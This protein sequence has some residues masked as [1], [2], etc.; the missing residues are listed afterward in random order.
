MANV[1]VERKSLED[2]ADAIREKLGVQYLIKPE[3]FAQKV[4]EIVPCTG[5]WGRVVYYT[6]NTYTTTATVYLS[7]QQEVNAMCDSTNPRPLNYDWTATIGGVT[8]TSGS[9]KE[10]HIG[11][12]VSYLPVAFLSGCDR[13]Q[14]V[15]L[16]ES[17]VSYIPR[18]LLSVN[19]VVQP[20][21]STVALT[22]P[23][24]ITSIGDH[25]LSGRHYFNSPFTIPNSVTTIGEYFLN[26]CSN[27]D[28]PLT[29]PSGLAAINEGFMYGCRDFDRPLTIPSSVLTIGAYFLEDC[30]SFNQDITIPANVSSID[31]WFMSQCNN[32]TST[33]NIGDLPATTIAISPASF[34]SVSPGVPCYTTGITLSGTYATDWHERLPDSDGAGGLY[35]KL[36]VAS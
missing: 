36:I 26:V 17:T 29:L 22:L 23:P 16:S 19:T 28:Q 11:E 27:F 18:H 21:T 33:V 32:M 13:I 10:V 25:F 4:S 7:S 34:A 31:V 5:D 9:V 15:D 14:V 1:L 8:I 35:R 20:D 12:L 24:S 6:D 30:Q 3:E 2:I